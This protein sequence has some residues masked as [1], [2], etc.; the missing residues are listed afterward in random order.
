MSDICERTALRVETVG[1]I[2]KSKVFRLDSQRLEEK[3]ILPRRVKS[4][5]R[6]LL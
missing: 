2:S 1:T 6:I 5:A 3:I 4:A